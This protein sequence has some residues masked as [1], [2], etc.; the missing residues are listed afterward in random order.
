MVTITA[1]KF[2]KLH[3]KVL[4]LLEQVQHSDNKVI[5]QVICV[6]QY[7]KTVRELELIVLHYPDAVASLGEEKLADLYRAI[8]SRWR[9]DVRWLHRYNL[10]RPIL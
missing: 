8:F 3:T 10:K 2:F 1:A 4:A 9:G 7:Q 6:W 5:T